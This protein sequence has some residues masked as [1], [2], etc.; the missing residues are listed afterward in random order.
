M[1]A[2]IISVGTELLL[3][4]IINS[5]AQFL[6]QELAALG[7]NV[8][9]QSTIGDNAARLED[10]IA[11]AKSRADIIILT[12]GLGPTEDDLTKEVLCKFVD[13]S[14]VEHKASRQAID[15]RFEQT[16]AEMT[17][18]NLKQAL[19]IDGSTVFQND[20][21][22][23]PGMAYEKDNRIY[24]LLP[25]P[26]Q[27]LMPMFIDKVVPYLGRF[28]EGVIL[29]RTV[30]VF[31][32]GESKVASLLEKF[33]Q[34]DNP[35][36][37][38][39]AKDGEV[40]VRVTAKADS[41]DLAEAMLNPVIKTISALLSPHV[42]GVDA[43]S[44][45]HVVVDLLKKKRLKV[46]TAESCTAGLLSKKI[47][48]MAGSSDVFE[49][50]VTTYSNENKINV[51]NV[52][53]ETLDSY[54][55]VSI[56][57]ASAMALGVRALDNS[58]LGIGITGIA[59][60]EGGSPEKPVGLVYIA[61]TDGQY[62]WIKRMQAAKDASRDHIRNLASLHA[63]DVLK[64]YLAALPGL[65]AGGEPLRG[66]NANPTFL[67]A[68]LHEAADTK[69]IDS[70]LLE[71][72]A[73]VLVMHGT[74]TAEA[75]ASTLVQ[76]T[77]FWSRF[78]SGRRRVSSHAK[79]PVA[80]AEPAENYT[81]FQKVLHKFLGFFP[82]RG[83]DTR[84]IIRKSVFLLAFV[85]FIVSGIILVNELLIK[86]LLNN[87]YNNQ[88]RTLLSATP[89]DGVEMPDGADER[90]AALYALN[91][92][93]RGWINI[94]DTV[95]DYPVMW[96]EEKGNREGEFYLNHDFEKRRNANGTL[97]FD[98]RN[99]IEPNA[100]NRNLIIY[101]HE[102]NSGQM[103]G[104][105]KKYKSLVYYQEHP[106][107]QMD[108]LYEKAQWK[109]FG[110]FIA[111]VHAEQG[112]PFNYIQTY[113]ENDEEFLDFTDHIKLRSLL[114]IPVDIEPGDQLLTLSTCI[115]DIYDGRLVVVARKVRPDE[116]LTVNLGDARVNPN[117]M[118]PDI[119]YINRKRA[120]PDFSSRYPNRYQQSQNGGYDPTESSDPSSS[121]SSAPESAVSSMESTSSTTSSKTSSN[122]G[123]S[124]K[125]PAESSTAPPPVSPEPP[126]VSST[127]PPPPVSSEEPVDSPEP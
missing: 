103:F 121:P 69:A 65:L 108:T 8:L 115:E 72:K 76:S 94:P 14:F 21:G 82:G 114:D 113:F 70:M 44:M 122:T 19:V 109:I 12:G 123:S 111:N 125:P 42:Y 68:V 45:Q 67:K 28:H 117:P 7:I 84:E 73:P 74:T 50:G 16:G 48:E 119:W 43:K 88:L 80:A 81:G 47:T 54:G 110:V 61:L 56:E 60:P 107:I 15:A 29:S 35:T 106:L 37:A 77:S 10:G 105:L 87:N 99:R 46:A 64:K 53:K 75:D 92:D 101:G 59:G 58:D 33:T 39:Y 40:L 63:L 27:E 5:D 118:Y 100:F 31:G 24:I 104:S 11:L 20:F 13:G 6:S 79:A 26:P 86:P 38:T 1:N 9:F 120:V 95:I 25:G 98:T 49:L 89:P 97:F 116:S 18:N 78:F 55:A 96:T 17:E 2:E 34:F 22:T 102:M 36:T 124:S 41:A 51:L 126:P 66:F 91:S 23:A 71:E 3:G 62:V 127:E 85:T 30:N 90:Y 52:K 57:T 4:D 93:F 112:E 32:L 83:D